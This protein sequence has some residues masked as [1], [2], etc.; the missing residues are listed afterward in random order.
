MPIVA[1]ITLY[2]NTIPKWQMIKA[3]SVS[4]TKEITENNGKPGG[5][6]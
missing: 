1:E 2:E 6:E 3:G 5:Q 4:K